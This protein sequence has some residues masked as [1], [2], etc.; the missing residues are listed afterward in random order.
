MLRWTR[1]AS[2]GARLLNARAETL[3]EKPAFRDA[4]R[5]R[6][7]LIPPSGLHQW[8]AEGGRK[9][10]YYVQ[11]AREA[12]F[13]FACFYETSNGLDGVLRNVHHRDDASQRR[14]ASGVCAHA[15]DRAKRALRALAKFQRWRRG[16]AAGPMRTRAR[17]T[18][19]SQA[20]RE[21]R[22]GE[23]AVAHRDRPAR[24]RDQRGTPWVVCRLTSN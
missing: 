6:R 15:G 14:F 5:K 16:R 19:P 11:P 18:A 1:H 3:A 17:A 22:A 10:P 9:Q 20:R 24:R 12:S 21:P 7:C 23:R 8:N 2:I 13:A 4:L